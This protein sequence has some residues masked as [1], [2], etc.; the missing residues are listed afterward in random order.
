[1]RPMVK[2][3]WFFLRRKYDVNKYPSNTLLIF[4]QKSHY[5]G[6]D[7]LY[8]FLC[9]LHYV[10]CCYLAF[11]NSIFLLSAFERQLVLNKRIYTKNTVFIFSLFSVD[12]YATDLLI[13]YVV[14]DDM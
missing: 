9:E 5:S 6:H 1:M 7:T 2:Q 11:F 14:K 13:R 4:S 8:Y 12:L 10:G 3:T